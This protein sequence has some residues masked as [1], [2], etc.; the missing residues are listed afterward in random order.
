MRR[1]LDECCRN[2]DLQ[3]KRTAAIQAELDRIRIAW[4]KSGGQRRRITD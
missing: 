4:Q 3:F 2:I 1:T